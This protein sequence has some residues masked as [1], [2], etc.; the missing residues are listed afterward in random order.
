M[1]YV[2]ILLLL[3]AAALVSRDYCGYMNKRSLECKDF[4]A[5]IAHMRIQVGCFLRP[6]KKLGE[7][8]SS[9]SLEKAGFLD[10][11]SDSE[12]IIDA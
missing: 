7:G 5:F 11:L 12:R 4:L 6:V 3:A 10:S 9:P 2:G 1:K 8:F